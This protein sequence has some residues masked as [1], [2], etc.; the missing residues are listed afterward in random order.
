M[1]LLIS[2]CCVLLRDRLRGRRLERARSVDVG[3]DG[4]EVEEV[5]MTLLA[6]I[7][8]MAVDVLLMLVLFPNRAVSIISESKLEPSSRLDNM[9]LEVE[10]DEVLGEFEDEL[11]WWWFRN[12]CRSLIDCSFHAD[13]RHWELYKNMAVVMN[14]IGNAIPYPAVANPCGRYRMAGPTIPLMIPRTAEVRSPPIPCACGSSEEAMPPDGGPPP[15]CIPPIPGPPEDVREVVM[16]DE[17][18]GSFPFVSSS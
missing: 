18:M 11:C 9:E 16:E 2:S 5:V 12:N 4:R 14:N 1:L 6:V 17:E 13:R 8:E 3:V 10:L 7:V 15:D